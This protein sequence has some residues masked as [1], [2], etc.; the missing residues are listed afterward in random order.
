MKGSLEDIWEAVRVNCWR[1]D[2]AQLRDMLLAGIAAR[3]GHRESK[4]SQFLER[5]SIFL[6]GRFEKQLPVSEL[7]N[8]RALLERDENGYVSLPPS[9]LFR[10]FILVYNY[11]SILSISEIASRRR[12]FAH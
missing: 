12:K 8:R 5:D 1:G 4:I 6:I 7:E 9:S 3:C 10:K 11:L 2:S